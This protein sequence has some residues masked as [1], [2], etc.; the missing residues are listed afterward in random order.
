MVTIRS[1]KESSCTLSS[2]LVASATIISQIFV[3]RSVCLQQYFL[4]SQQLNQFSAWGW[5]TPPYKAHP[6][7]F[8]HWVGW[9]HARTSHS[10]RAA[11]SVYLN[12]SFARWAWR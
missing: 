12:K 3:V 8:L 11:R 4:F 6:V 10:L 9:Y 5:L 1:R 7:V 2:I